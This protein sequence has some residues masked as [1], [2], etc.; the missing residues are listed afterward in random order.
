MFDIPSLTIDR[1]DYSNEP[2][3]QKMMKSVEGRC[4]SGLASCTDK[5]KF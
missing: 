4:D 5:N 3:V 2:A 1:V